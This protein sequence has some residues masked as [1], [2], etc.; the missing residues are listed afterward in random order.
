MAEDLK[1]QV[2]VNE[3]EENSSKD[4]K[5]KKPN[6]V[7]KLEDEILSLK[8]QL[9]RNQAELE[10]FK[11]RMNE[12]RIKD[13]K[14]AMYDFLMESIETFDIFN[15]AVNVSTDDEKLKKYL[16]G[17]KMIDNRFSNILSNYG[18]KQIDCLNKPFDPAFHSALDT[19]EKEGVEPNTVIEVV[20]TG[21]MY[22][23][24]VLRPAMVK[25]SK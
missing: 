8:D 12:E 14:Y 6:K 23:D 11:K 3:K 22:K 19:I 13:R 7:K 25:V 10:N 17:F 1:E 5:E 24:R 18:V 2:E 9:L 4:V 15:K 20:M 21:Y 16:D